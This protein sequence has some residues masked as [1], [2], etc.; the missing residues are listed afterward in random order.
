MTFFK[1]LSKKQKVLFIIFSILSLFLICFI[2]S[3]SMKNGSDSS[4]DSEKVSRFVANVINFIFKTEYTS[5]DVGSPVRTFAHFSE[6]AALSFCLSSSIRCITKK[7]KFFYLISI[8]F[9]VFIAIIDE[10]IQIFSE[11]RAFQFTDICV[12]SLGGL[13]GI[14]FLCVMLKIFSFK[15]NNKR[16]IVN[17]KIKNG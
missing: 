13:F 15:G 7:I 16:N 5:D 9:T 12:D 8:P 10:I 6:F 14:V 11:G 1:K 2:F 4:K 3:N 17:N